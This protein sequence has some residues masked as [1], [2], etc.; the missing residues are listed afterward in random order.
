MLTCAAR[1]EVAHAVRAELLERQSS[2]GLEEKEKKEKEAKEEPGRAG[3]GLEGRTF[4]SETSR[5]TIFRSPAS[6]LLYYYCFTTAYYYYNYCFTT[7]L[8]LLYYC[9]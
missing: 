7:A 3:V 1:A 2:G 5:I 4:R 6:L 8:L 9:M